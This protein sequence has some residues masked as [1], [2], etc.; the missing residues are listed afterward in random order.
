MII[1]G[2]AFFMASVN[3][4]LRRMG[5]RS[6]ILHKKSL[7]LEREYRIWETKSR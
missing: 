2:I 7:M 6:V 5:A 3:L 1:E 4:R